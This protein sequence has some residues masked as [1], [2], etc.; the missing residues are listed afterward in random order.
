VNEPGELPLKLQRRLLD[1][2]ESKRFH[3]VGSNDWRH[4]DAQLI[5]A[6]HHDLRAQVTAGSFL[7]GLRR[8]L[9]LVEAWV[10]PLK[11]R[12]EDI[13]PLVKHFL[14]AWNMPG[15][16][17]ELLPETI[18]LLEAHDWPNNVR[19]LRDTVDRLAVFGRL[20]QDGLASLLA[21]TQGE[22]QTLEKLC[23][24]PIRTARKAIVER[25]ERAYLKR[26]LES[27]KGNVT[28]AATSAGVSRQLLHRLLARYG[29]T[30]SER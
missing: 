12:K 22:D 8:R 20:G 16:A 14:T 3:Q 11:D 2:L 29:F 30:P 9:A 6:S 13:R 5:T 25:L 7:E 21:P 28:K 23:H 26:L 1:A 27:H 15:A 10:P 17:S 24:L 18:A 19:E 4:F